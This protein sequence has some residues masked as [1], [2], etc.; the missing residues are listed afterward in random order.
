MRFWDES[1]RKILKKIF[2][3]V[4]VLIGIVILLMG[5]SDAS[6]GFGTTKDRTIDLIKYLGI[7]VVLV[8]IPIF[9][10]DNYKGIRDKFFLFRKHTFVGNLLGGFIVYIAISCFLMFWVV[11]LDGLHTEKYQNEYEKYYAALEKE[12]IEE[13]QKIIE[14]KEAKE[15]VAK[16]KAE[17]EKTSEEKVAQEKVVKKKVTKEKVAKDNKVQEKK[18]EEKPTKEKMTMKKA[19]EEKKVKKV[20]KKASDKKETVKKKKKTENG[21]GV[22]GEECSINDLKKDSNIGKEIT[23]YGEYWSMAYNGKR[24]LFFGNERKK[25]DTIVSTHFYVKDKTPKKKLS[26]LKEKSWEDEVIVKI[27]GTYE[28]MDAVRDDNGDVEFYRFKISASNIK[29]LDE[30]STKAKEIKKMF[31]DAKEGKK[32]NTA[33]KEDKN[34]KDY[35]YMG[36]TINLSNNV[37]YTFVDCGEYEENLYDGYIYN[38]YVYIEL[39]VENQG[40]QGY[41]IVNNDVLFYGDGYCLERGYPSNADYTISSDITSGRKARVRFYAECNN[42]DALSSIEVEFANIPNLVFVIKK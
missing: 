18:A 30:S 42:Y 13:E 3:I 11:G 20:A 21:L 10:V 36:D 27:V 28:G 12:D 15:K 2:K 32:E 5:V 9:L 33:V 40:N 39:E 29:I 35:Y 8:I 7:V 41:S 4:M 19:G 16:E 14:E 6:N 25:D 37:K 23:I 26:E 38:K 1:K 17:K 31:A 24:Y 22:Y 34:K